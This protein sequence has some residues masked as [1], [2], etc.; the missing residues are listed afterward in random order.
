M[1][2]LD[3]GTELEGLLARLEIGEN[4]TG[5]STMRSLASETKSDRIQ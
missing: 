2:G 3:M 5:L 1:V 4:T